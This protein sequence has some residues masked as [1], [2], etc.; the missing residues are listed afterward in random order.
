MAV[1]FEYLEPRTVHEAISLLLCYGCV[2][3]LIVGGIDLLNEIRSKQIAP[4]YI[5]DIGAIPGIDSL[6]YDDHGTLSIG[7]LATLRAVE[8]SPQV[9]KHHTV[10]SQAAGQ[11]G[12]VAIETSEPSRAISVMPAS[13]RYGTLP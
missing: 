2:A 8:T 6:T 12:S 13:R 9:K 7:A 5:I 3:K 1:R 10:I 4:E 11:I